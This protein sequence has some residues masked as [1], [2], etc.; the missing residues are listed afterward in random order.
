MNK[1]IWKRANLWRKKPTAELTLFDCC[2]IK[3][4]TS[5]LS[6]WVRCTVA[7]FSWQSTS[8]FY[9]KDTFKVRKLILRIYPTHKCGALGKAPHFW[10]RACHLQCGI[11][12]FALPASPWCPLSQLRSV[13]C[14]E[15]FRGNHYNLAAP[16]PVQPGFPQWV[17]LACFHPAILPVKYAINHK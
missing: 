1:Q 16:L 15:V 8:I 11:L 14:V 3:A 7:L 12:V 17:K 4:K 5:N 6:M 9:W 13:P 2:L 10:G